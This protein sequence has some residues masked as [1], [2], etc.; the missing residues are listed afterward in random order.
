M[1]EVGNPIIFEV[2]SPTGSR[3]NSK[4]RQILGD[5]I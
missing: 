1:S 3:P 5:K 4:E 2:F